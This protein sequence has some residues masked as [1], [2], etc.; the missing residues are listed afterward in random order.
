MIDI[1]GSVDLFQLSLLRSYSTMLYG[2][3]NIE[4]DMTHGTDDEFLKIHMTRM[5]DTFQTRHGSMIGVFVLHGYSI[6]L[7]ENL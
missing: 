4:M 3:G 5:S 1:T 7:F 6:G 2:H